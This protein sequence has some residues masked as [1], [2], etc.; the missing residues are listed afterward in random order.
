M[1]P[2]MM[3]DSADGSNFTAMSRCCSEAAESQP[4]SVKHRHGHS[5][6]GK[7]EV[8]GTEHFFEKIVRCSRVSVPLG[9]L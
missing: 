4:R 1:R 8:R 7:K 3:Q 9:T 5:T 6:S 2:F